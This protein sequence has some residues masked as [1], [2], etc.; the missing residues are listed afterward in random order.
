MLLN[1]P[2][3]PAP[4]GSRLVPDAAAGFPVVSKDGK[5][6]T[7]SLR[8]GLK[9]SDGSPVTAAA[10]KH[11]FE[12]AADPR[13]GSPAV[14]FLHQVIGADERADGKAA[15]VAGVVAKG[16]KLTVRLHQADPSSSP[17]SR[18]PSSQR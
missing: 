16:Q 15:S 12:R 4:E 8:S 9:F 17:R 18:C 2:D 1:Y 11:A 10:F 3:K 5:T 14:A 7:C 13:Q 6:Y